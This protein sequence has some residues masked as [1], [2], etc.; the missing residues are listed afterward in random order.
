[1]LFM[2]FTKALLNAHK[3]G[4]MATP[5]SPVSRPCREAATAPYLSWKPPV[6][7]GLCRSAG[8]RPG[9]GRGGRGGG[10]GRLPGAP[11]R[12]V[13]SERS[14]SGSALARPPG[15]RL[16]P[17]MAVPENLPLSP[18][19]R[20]PPG[21]GGAPAAPAKAENLPGGLQ[22]LARCLFLLKR[23]GR[24]NKENKPRRKRGMNVPTVC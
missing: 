23:K 19:Q 14:C 10:G 4:L 13:L 8:R 20:Q 7:A 24:K 16:E 3:S 17:G 21:P 2:K 12:A 9:R 1:M 11:C 22:L 15:H 6:F 5:P 18:G